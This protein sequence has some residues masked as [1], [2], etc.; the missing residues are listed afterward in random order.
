[1]RR[2]LATHFWDNAGQVLV[3]QKVDSNRHHYA[4]E[5]K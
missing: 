3:V 1:M 2:V 5:V 4:E